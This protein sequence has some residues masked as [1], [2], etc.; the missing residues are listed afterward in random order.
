[1][2][3]MRAEA[4]QSEARAHVLH[5]SLIRGLLKSKHGTKH[6]ALLGHRK[7]SS[8]WPTQPLHIFVFQP[9][10]LLKKGK[11]LSF[12]DTK[13]TDLW[14]KRSPSS[15][16]DLTQDRQY[17]LFTPGCQHRQMQVWST[18]E[19]DQWPRFP[20]HMPTVT[21][22]CTRSVGVTACPAWHSLTRSLPDLHPY[23]L[24]RT[25]RGM[26]RRFI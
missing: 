2:T 15:I 18:D 5:H 9:T 20:Q 25:T 12:Y 26:Q 4:R 16:K 13:I 19:R 23:P 8:I 14:M 7:A 11:K 10:Y 1:M 21:H 6:T 22:D 24:H 3:E 17:K